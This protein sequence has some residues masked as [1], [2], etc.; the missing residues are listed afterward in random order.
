MCGDKPGETTQLLMGTENTLPEE[1]KNLKVYQVTLK[2]GVSIRVAILGSSL[3]GTQ[4]QSGKTFKSVA[5]IDT[6]VGSPRE[7]KVSE[8]IFEN[9]SMMLVRK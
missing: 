9:D 2:E 8:I 1:L 3:I 6:S 4:Y 7:I 5:I